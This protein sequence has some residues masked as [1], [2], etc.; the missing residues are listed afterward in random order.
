MLLICTLNFGNFSQMQEDFNDDGPVTSQPQP[1]QGT[2]SS[3]VPIAMPAPNPTNPFSSMA[4]E[5]TSLNT[6]EQA[7]YTPGN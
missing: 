6:S 3:N 4:T 5:A 1:G 7:T 2:S